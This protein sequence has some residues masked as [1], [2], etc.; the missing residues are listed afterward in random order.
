MNY[1]WNFSIS[2]RWKRFATQWIITSSNRNIDYITSKTIIS[3]ILININLPKKKK[4]NHYET[5]KKNPPSILLFNLTLLAKLKTLNKQCV[6]FVIFFL[7]TDLDNKWWIKNK[8]WFNK[9]NDPERLLKNSLQL[10]LIL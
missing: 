10:K 2:H 7:N 1:K 8:I 9:C 5:T 3:G 6:F 4:K